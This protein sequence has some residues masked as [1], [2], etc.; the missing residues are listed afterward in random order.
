[1]SRF[2]SWATLYRHVESE[3]KGRLKQHSSAIDQQVLIFIGLLPRHI[4]AGTRVAIPCS[5]PST[6]DG[7]TLK[8]SRIGIFQN[9]KFRKL[10]SAVTKAV[11]I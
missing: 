2:E 4:I 7:Q 9:Q 5:S 1:M 6:R 8:L 3:A 10:C 11:V